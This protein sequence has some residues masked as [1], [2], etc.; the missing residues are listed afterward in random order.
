MSRL[1]YRLSY[2]ALNMTV[3][4]ALAERRDVVI[5]PQYGIEP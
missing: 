5:E 3:P 4:R 1:L 2:A